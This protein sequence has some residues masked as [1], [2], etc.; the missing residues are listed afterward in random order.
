ME[1]STS[2]NILPFRLNNEA[3]KRA[4][5]RG[6]N[7]AISRDC[8]AVKEKLLSPRFFSYTKGLASELLRMRLS[9]Q[10]DRRAFAGRPACVENKAIDYY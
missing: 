2:K 5:H 4:C 1:N 3:H 7:F 8:S 9:I 6:K 10:K